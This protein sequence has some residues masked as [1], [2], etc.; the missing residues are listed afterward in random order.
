MM[1]GMDGIEAAQAIRALNTEYAKNI[2]IIALTANAILGNEEMF[3]S[4]GFQDYLTKPIDITRLDEVIR[5]W[6]RDKNQEPELDFSGGADGPGNDDVQGGADQGDADPAAEQLLDE[7]SRINGLDVE[8]GLKNV[9][10]NPE[11]Y[12]RA[13]RQFCGGCGGY[14]D[15]LTAAVKAGDWKNYSIK[16]HALK[17]V[18]AVFGAKER[19]EWAARLEKMSKEAGAGRTDGGESPAVRVCTE[20]TAPFCAAL[21]EFAGAL[22]DAFRKA[23]TSGVATG[24]KK[25]APTDGFFREQID[26]LENAC[27]ECSAAEAEKLIAGLLEY[28]WDEETDAGLARIRRFA[29]SY[30]Y[31]A[32]LEAINRLKKG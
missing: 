32:I 16:A 29:V 3:I 24:A 15:E 27:R 7:L 20:E 12:F 28:A 8:A 17:G 31:E 5:F 9:G 23:D 14:I 26:L 25:T 22:R 1:P 10:H 19:S 4:K 6:V 11:T 2:P 18:L 30:D 13:L 21:L